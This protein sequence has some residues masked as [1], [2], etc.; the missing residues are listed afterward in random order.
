MCWSSSCGRSCG[1]EDKVFLVNRLRLHCG[2]ADED[3]EDI[4]V[5]GRGDLGEEEELV[6]FGCVETGGEA[7]FDKEL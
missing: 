5:A 4:V 6:H 1:F 7:C 2:E 3:V